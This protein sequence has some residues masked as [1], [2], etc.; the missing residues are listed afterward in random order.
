[1][2]RL[3]LDGYGNMCSGVRFSVFVLVLEGILLGE[4]S[5]AVGFND[6]VGRRE[7]EFLLLLRN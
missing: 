7:L 3:G 6:Y 2:D 5:I 1:M 4:Y